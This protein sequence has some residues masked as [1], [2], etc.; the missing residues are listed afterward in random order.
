MT[1]D[2]EILIGKKAHWNTLWRVRTVAM[3]ALSEL[4]VEMPRLGLMAVALSP[5]SSK[6]L[7]QKVW[8]PLGMN[9]RAATYRRGVTRNGIRMATS[10]ERDPIPHYLSCVF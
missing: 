9:Q 5:P 4:D 8:Q 10:C 7:E 6:N 3:A 2:G 1:D